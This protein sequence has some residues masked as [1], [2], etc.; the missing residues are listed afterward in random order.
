MSTAEG[1]EEEQRLFYVAATRAR[2]SLRIY[3]PLRLPVH[4]TSLS[5][6]HVLTK[7]SR[8]LDGSALATMD[9]T[10]SAGLRDT[11]PGPVGTGPAAAP[12]VALPDLGA[13]FA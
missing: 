1:L 5:S 11:A 6:R 8:F 2:D 3:T 10:V 4:P 9:S 7:P 12:T 13:L